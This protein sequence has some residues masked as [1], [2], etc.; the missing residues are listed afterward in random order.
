M[1]KFIALLLV[2]TLA[3]AE[4]PS[5]EEA[6]EST[7]ALRILFK[8][9]NQKEHRLFSN[10]ETPLRLNIFKSSIQEIVDI[11][12]Q[13]LGWT[14][15]INKFATMTPAERALYVGRNA[16]I[17]RHSTPVVG[18]E[19]EV[20]VQA[21][22]VDWVRKGKVTSVKDQY[23]STCWSYST[24]H[25]VEGAY[26]VKTGRL[27]EA[28]PQ[29]LVDCVYGGSGYNNGGFQNDAL[30]WLKSNQVMPSWNSY[31]PFRGT[32]R[33]N[34]R[35]YRNALTGV[36]FAGF[37]QI[38]QGEAAL[39]SALNIS[40]TTTNYHVSNGNY[41]YNGGIYNDRSCRSSYNS[42]NH[43]VTAVGYDSS[44]FKIKNSWGTDWGER[45]YGRF[46][47]RGNN[48]GITIDNLLAKLDRAQEKEE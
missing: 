29:L 9:H 11:N 22:S 38:R 8:A 33:C 27:V 44:S 1:I 32:N 48:C 6:L 23:S 40:P 25:A 34:V 28:T 43:A 46:S 39:V 10:K 12:N 15:G 3:T 45:G 37:T 21:S 14:A 47:R 13:H 7:S 24:T 30:N 31:R 18:I 19:P 5:L 4:L 35:G 36:R 26:A 41:Y 42:L 20:K 17:A 16:T 2:A